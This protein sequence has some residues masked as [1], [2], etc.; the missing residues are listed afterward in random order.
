[1]YD[2]EI[3][4]HINPH[5]EQ[6]KQKNLYSFAEIVIKIKWVVFWTTM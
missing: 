5:C 4:H 3:I 6:I 1:M 2:A